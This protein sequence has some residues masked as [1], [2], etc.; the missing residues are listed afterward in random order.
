MALPF[1]GDGELPARRMAKRQE[2]LHFSGKCPP[3][4]L[5]K[6]EVPASPARSLRAAR[7][8][9]Q[10][11]DQSRLHELIQRLV[12]HH[13]PEANPTSGLLEHLPYDG[14]SVPVLVGERQQDVEPVGFERPC[15][16]F[17]QENLRC[18]RSVLY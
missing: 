2:S 5:G 18:Y 1:A 14:T 16:V 11:D 15:A 10:F 4:A 8:I 6:V 17:R 3:S 9:R 7:W 13:G 12:E